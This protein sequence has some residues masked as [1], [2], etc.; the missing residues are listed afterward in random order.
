MT[1]M[2]IYKYSLVELRNFWGKPSHKYTTFGVNTIEIVEMNNS[3]Y[4]LPPFFHREQKKLHNIK[5]I[6]IFFARYFSIFAQFFRFSLTFFA[7]GEKMRAKN[8]IDNCFQPF[9]W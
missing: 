8:M 3:S 1:P 6:V 9:R 7:H 4:F 5:K 2:S